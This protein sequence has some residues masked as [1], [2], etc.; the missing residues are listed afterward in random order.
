[1]GA[2]RFVAA[3]S[4]GDGHPLIP[5]AR[6]GE[7]LRVHRDRRLITHAAG[8]TF[9]AVADYLEGRGEAD[10][11]AAWWSIGEGRLHDV[12]ILDQLLRLARADE[13]PA[14]RPLAAL[15]AEY[16]GLRLPDDPVD[17]GPCGARAVLDAAVA[18]A[19]AT[20]EVYGQ[21]V[22][23]AGPFL[24][25]TG[26]MPEALGRFG[27]L[28]ETIQV[29]GAIAL[30]RVTR[31]GLHVDE[32]HRAAV[33]AHLRSELERLTAELRA[34]P[35]GDDLFH[36]DGQ[37]QV[38]RTDRG[39]TPRLRRDRLRE[40]LLDAF[41]AIGP[42]D[43][44]LPLTAEGAVSLAFT[45]WAPL[46]P[47]HPFLGRWVDL[48]RAADGC[49][50]LAEL[51]G[52]VVHPG[53]RL[54]R[55]GRA[56]SS[57]PNIQGLP[58]AGGIREVVVAAPG[59]LLLAADYTCLELRTLAA[60][61]LSRYGTSALADVLRA[62]GDPHA[63][64]AARLEGQDPAEFLRMKDGDRERFAALRQRAKA[65][66]FGI[67]GGLG[68][69]ELASYAR[70][71]YGVD[72]SVAEAEAFRDR[73]I[74]EVYPELAMYLADD[75]M[76]VLA[77]NLGRAPAPLW[78][79]FDWAGDRSPAVPGGI[80]R[81]VRG[82]AGREDGTP[83]SPSY[84]ARVWSVLGR[85]NY[86]TDLAAPLARRVG[87]E[88]LADRLFRRVAVTP[89]GRI[90]GGV[91]APQAWNTPFQ[92]L[93]ADGAKLALWRL[94][95]AG[96]R[97]VGFVHDEVL[98]ELPAAGGSVPRVAVD[99]ALGILRAG[100]EEVLGDIPAKLSAGLS[101]RWSKAARLVDRGDRVYPADEGASV[102]PTG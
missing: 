100:M 2:G 12:Q 64:T 26:E 82:R 102:G 1:M 47:L 23:R 92:G 21:L 75:A 89:T 77:A 97:V 95:R 41:A 62:G 43:Y 39:R 88:A 59:H 72:I 14:S 7:F 69:G 10:A 4:A 18:R 11:L 78:T 32:A 81:V 84:I 74:T 28:T 93:A 46:A 30:Q 96:F 36:L 83:Y 87:S 8:A 48:E 17:A 38:E 37:G 91:T 51:S 79:W 55:T 94:T 67:P 31:N 6:L 42:G 99:E 19:V 56:A 15:A 13:R 73:L 24:P 44:P 22:R 25:T 85:L 5:A 34:L 45:A 71:A 70:A 20:R 27:P 60:V 29:R 53:Y 50:H 16:A 57:A 9:W 33:E 68:T 58:R 90:R 61:C 65:I 52:P 54:L 101:R 49:R 3:A 98:V 40:R 86:N 63:H 35:G 66:N 80:R 76:E